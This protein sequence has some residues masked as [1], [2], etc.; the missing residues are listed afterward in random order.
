MDFLK[1]KKNPCSNERNGD[2]IHMALRTYD[3][4]VTDK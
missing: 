1:K 3:L 2:L 4:K